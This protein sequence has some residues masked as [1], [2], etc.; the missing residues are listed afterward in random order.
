VTIAAKIVGVE[1]GATSQNVD[2]RWLMAYAAALGEV[3]PRYY[4][5]TAPAGPAAHPLFP[6]GYEWTAALRLRART[7][8]ADL[9]PYGVHA[10]HR[11]VIHR[12]PQAGDRLLTRA[13]VIAVRPSRSGTLV[14]SRFSTVNRNGQPVTTTDYGTV[15]RGVGVDGDGETHAAVEVLPKIEAPIAQ[16]PRWEAAIAVSAQAAHVYSECARIWNPIHTDLAAALA[17]GL[18][19]LILHGTA[20]LALAVSRLVG[21]ELG[22]DPSRVRQVA[23]RMTGMVA[24]PSS[25]TL[26]CLAHADAVIAFD[27]VDV[28]GRPVLSSGLLQSAP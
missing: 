27:A 28:H 5:T 2:A 13:Q 10:S 14:V 7:I 24:L 11:T 23:A 12:A 6:V 19:G 20:T 21:E 8:R 3:D 4:D 16:A 26:R 9:H 22:G 18:P 25:F 17:A 1:T 15:Y